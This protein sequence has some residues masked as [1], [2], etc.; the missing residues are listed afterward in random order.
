MGEGLGVRA[1]FHWKFMASFPTPRKVFTFVLAI[2]SAILAVVCV[3]T[4]TNNHTGIMTYGWPGSVFEL[5]KVIGPLTDPL[6]T[7]DERQ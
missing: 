6:L 2:P 1:L 4:V 7:A 5:L 3:S